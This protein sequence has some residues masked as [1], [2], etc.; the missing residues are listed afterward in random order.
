M[1]ITSLSM[2]DSNSSDL[3]VEAYLSLLR[4]A[5]NNDVKH[6][7]YLLAQDLHKIW[8]NGNQ[9]FICGN[10]GS[11]ANA[12][13]LSNDFHYGVAAS[14]QDSGGLGLR[15]EALTSNPAIITCLANDISYEQI[16][17]HQINVKGNESDILLILSGSGNSANILR[18]VDSAKAIGMK[19]Y[20]ILGFDGGACK[21]LLDVP[22]HLAVDDM[23][24]SEDLQLIIGHLCM[25][26]LC[27]CNQ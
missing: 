14:S 25:Q 24:I 23:Q 2:V 16:F 7:I 9:L 27:K 4:S 17:S 20:G 5:F 8:M 3:G 26:Y 19:S 10:G 6:K 11:A 15:V 12:I 21:S 22:I 1:P 13:H 18:A